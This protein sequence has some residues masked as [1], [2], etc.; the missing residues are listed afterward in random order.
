MREIWSQINYKFIAL[1]PPSTYLS[2][3]QWTASL[4]MSHLAD[5]HP[6]YPIFRLPP[7]KY[8]MQFQW[9]YSGLCALE[10]RTR[11]N[12]GQVPGGLDQWPWVIFGPLLLPWCMRFR[13]IRLLRF[14]PILRWTQQCTWRSRP[15]FWGRRRPFKDWGHLGQADSRP[16]R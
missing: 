3:R 5:S 12:W 13:R 15:W 7:Q 11:W 6:S 2:F 16:C 14:V 4:P 10:R 8:V 1:I 9:L